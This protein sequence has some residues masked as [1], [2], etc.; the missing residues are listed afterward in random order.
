M[1][2][3]AIHRH[4]LSAQEL[5]DYQSEPR[6]TEHIG[7]LGPN[8]SWIRLNQNRL[9]VVGEVHNQIT[10]QDMVAALN[11]R[12]YMDEGYSFLPDHLHESF[13]EL[14]ACN[15]SPNSCSRHLEHP[16]PK[17]AFSL[18]YIHNWRN[19]RGKADGNAYDGSQTLANTFH[20]GL[21]IAQDVYNQRNNNSIPV[22]RALANEWQQ[23]SNV[24][25]RMIED[26]KS[27]ENYRI[28]GVIEKNLHQITTRHVM[29]MVGRIMDFLL[30]ADPDASP[31]MEQ[32]RNIRKGVRR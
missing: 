24:W 12:R 3:P 11:N 17:T 8:H 32:K 31:S 16:F 15:K 13:P 28:G 25:L 21:K 19:Y 18:T 14:M 27:E 9:L 2:Y 20:T 30:E 10:M 5:T 4:F 26:I 6:K 1:H 22:E 7:T 23:W 29:S